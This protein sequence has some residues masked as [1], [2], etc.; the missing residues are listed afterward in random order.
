M[1]SLSIL[2]K[3]SILSKNKYGDDDMAWENVFYVRKQV[4]LRNGIICEGGPYAKKN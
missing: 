2:Y 3:K 1:G 4:E